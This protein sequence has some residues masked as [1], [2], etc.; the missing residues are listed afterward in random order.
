[1][2][3][4]ISEQNIREYNNEVLKYA[5]DSSVIKMIAN[6]TDEQLSKF[7]FKPLVEEDI[8]EYDPETQYL[9]TSY[10]D[11]EDYITKHYEVKDI[12]EPEVE[13][14]EEE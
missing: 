7:G 10:I 11:G 14:L 6:P 1:M 9:E 13:N 4:F 8:P 3:Y 2:Y 5:L 12:P